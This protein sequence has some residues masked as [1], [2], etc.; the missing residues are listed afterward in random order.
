M[1]SGNKLHLV[2]TVVALASCQ[3]KDSALQP[4][5]EPHVTPAATPAS[6]PG[7]APVAGPAGQAGARPEADRAVPPLPDPLPGKRTNV[8]A[9]VGG[10]HRVAIGDLDG[11]GKNEIVLAD[12]A[13][14]RVIEPSGRERASV[15]VEGGIQVLVVADLDGDKR[16][17]IYA[18]WGISREHMQTKVSVDAYRLEGDKLVRERVIAPETSRQDVAAIVPIGSELLIGYFE[19]KYI[20]RSVIARRTSGWT[21]RELATIRMATSYAHADLDGDGK[22]ELVVGRVYGDD[23]GLDGDVF[24][25]GADGKRTPIPTTRGARELAVADTDGD[26]RPELFIADGWHQNYGQIARGLVTWVRHVGGSYRAELVEDTA[27]QYSA[28]KL[29]PG[30]VDADGRA[31]IVSMGS[32][33]VRVFDRTEGTW[34][35]LTVGGTARDVAVGDLDGVPGAEILIVAETSEIVSLAPR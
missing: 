11:D 1:R 30:D 16:A 13:T 14:L 17:E 8:T 19:S 22:A 23:K 15:T 26:G 25:L 34:V 21:T 29:V 18:G 4:A 28:G 7:A 32:H 24:V 6:P 35:G 33:Y 12:A 3:R 10:A 2:A 9:L 20:V 5:Q 27:G 31:E